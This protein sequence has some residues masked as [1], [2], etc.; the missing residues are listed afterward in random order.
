MYLQNITVFPLD[1]ITEIC[2]KIPA[3]ILKK[4]TTSEVIKW[5]ALC[6]DVAGHDFEHIIKYHTRLIKMYYFVVILIDSIILEGRKPKTRYLVMVNNFKTTAVKL[7]ESLHSSKLVFTV[8]AGILIYLSTAIANNE[9]QYYR[10]LALFQI[11]SNHLTVPTKH[12]LPNP[13][14]SVDAETVDIRLLIFRSKN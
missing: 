2:K 4:A 1:Q 14:Y 8:I 12:Y 9:L 13:Y 10:N 7:I 3:S 11:N 5:L 6:L